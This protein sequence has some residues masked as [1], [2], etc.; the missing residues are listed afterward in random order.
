LGAEFSKKNPQKQQKTANNRLKSKKTP[1]YTQ[2]SLKMHRGDRRE[3]LFAC[4]LLKNVL[5]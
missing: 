1:I 4:Y 5:L 2:I 3:P